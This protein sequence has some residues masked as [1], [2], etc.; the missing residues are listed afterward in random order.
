MRRK[1]DLS[2]SFNEEQHLYTGCDGRI[3]KSVTETVNSYFTLF[4][5]NTIITGM[6]SSQNWPRSE[7][8]GKTKEEIKL[9]WKEAAAVGTRMHA[10]IEAMI[11]HCCTETE[12]GPRLDFDALVELSSNESNYT[13]IEEWPL[14]PE[15]TKELVREFTMFHSFVLTRPFYEY[16]ACEMRLFH[17]EKGIAGTA[18]LL[19]YDDQ[20]HCKL[21]DWKRTKQLRMTSRERGKAPFSHLENCN[22]HHFRLQLNLY[23]F[24]IE[25]CYTLGGSLPVVEEMNVVVFHPNNENFLLLPIEEDQAVYLI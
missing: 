9:Q 12:L 18:D 20:G 17:S 15:Q 23:K 8:F 6:M 10:G 21:F 4:N 14:F 25:S 2:L 13:S 3:F 19:T 5:S 7:Y 1:D 16:C 11:K 22:S 24:L